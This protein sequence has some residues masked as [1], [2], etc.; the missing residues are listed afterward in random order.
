[1]KQ[2]EMTIG[3]EVHVQLKTNTKIWD[4]SSAN[5][6]E[7]EPNT[8]ISPT[9]VGL[10][11]SLPVINEKAV[12]Y[13][14]FAALALN[15]DINKVSKFDRKNYFYPDSP[16]NYQITQY[17]KPYAENGYIKVGDRKIRIER[18]QIEED[19]AKS[20]H[21]GNNSYLNFNRASMPLIEI[22]SAPDIKTPQ[23]AY[24]YLTILKE[25][26]KYTGIS[27]VS[28][29]LGS[30]RCDVNVSIKEKDSDK[31]GART[32][33]KNLNSFK[34]VMK[35]IEY[36]VNRQS[37]IL[38]RGEKVVQETLLWDDELGIT[39][40]MRSKE[41]SMDYRYFPEPDL[42]PLIITEEQILK[43]KDRMP[44][45]SDK[46]YERYVNEFNIGD[47][48]A[49]KL[50]SSLEL[51][52]YFEKLSDYIDDHKMASNWIL[53]EVLRVLNEK[54][55]EINDFIDSKKLSEL[56]L[57]IKN[58]NIN[59]KIG[60]E[61]FEEMV[62]TSKSAKEII[63]S[64]NISQISDPK[65]IEKIVSEVL[66]NNQESVSDLKNGKDRAMKHLMGQ[67]MKLSKGRANPQ[68]ITQEILR[69]IGE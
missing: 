6:D 18:I 40:P 17:F 49:K 10:P 37:E 38:S 69:Q 39:K 31:L 8:C 66:S 55:I 34:A 54:H 22:V 48:E 29:E 25:R 42:L 33:T 5:Y 13:A 15:C 44:E 64:K 51:A 52:N 47:M 2:Y 58:G 68:L 53:T 16:K 32:E 63:A 9:S 21:I 56:L 14:L 24:D 35:A 61:I 1:M 23:E 50:T 67:A 62:N 4:S 26:I 45:F 7:K 3:L 60:K 12:E 59:G 46:K 20:I 30:L 57:E 11:G 28:M 65:E 27:D 41:E 43:I 36:E 19:T